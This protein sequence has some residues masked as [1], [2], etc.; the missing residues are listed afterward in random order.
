MIL[1]ITAT[2]RPHPSASPDNAETVDTTAVETLPPIKTMPVEMLLNIA[3]YLEKE[4]FFNFR[5]ADRHIDAV[6]TQSPEL[7]AHERNHSVRLCEQ[8]EEA[9]TVAQLAPPAARASRFLRRPLANEQPQQYD[10]AVLDALMKAFCHVPSKHLAMADRLAAASMCKTLRLL[11]DFLRKSNSIDTPARQ[12]LN[13]FWARL[14]SSLNGLP[15]YCGVFNTQGNH[16]FRS[17]QA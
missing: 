2:I 1:P 5:Q 7:V 10:Q 12:T 13:A 17:M 11:D 3:R 4:D 16:L 14:A 15:A 6:L 8:I 9:K